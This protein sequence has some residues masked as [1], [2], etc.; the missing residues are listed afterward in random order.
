M[1]R[2]LPP[3]SYLRPAFLPCSLKKASSRSAM[4]DTTRSP[5]SGN[6]WSTDELLAYNI[7]IQTQSVVDFFGHEL[8]PIDL[9]PYLFSSFSPSTSSRIPTGMSMP[10]H[11][12]LSHLTLISHDAQDSFLNDFAISVLDVTNFERQLGTLLVPRYN[13]P[14]TICGNNDRKAIVDICL[15]S[16]QLVPMILLVVQRDKPVFGPSGPEPPVVAGAI[17]TFQYNNRSR[18][19]MGLPTLDKM[20]I[21]CITVEG[22]RPLFYKVPVTQHLSDC[23][24]TGQFP[25][26]Q[27]VVTRCGPPTPLEAHEGMKSPDYR[28]IALYY[29]EAFRDLAEDCWAPFLSGCEGE[30][31]Q[32]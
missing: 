16:A 14:L 32:T 1:L 27:T 23:V 31:P 3:L 17:A 18:A 26:Q 9:D 11:R 20:T 2:L 24:A 12:F 4:A 30:W 5:K 21:P 15:M 19:K 7:T 10:T 29:Y 6:H 13:L 8:S 28:R 22:T 25:T